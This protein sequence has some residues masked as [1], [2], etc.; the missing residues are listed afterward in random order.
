M[1]AS[2]GVVPHAERHELLLAGGADQL[3]QIGAGRP[4]RVDGDGQGGRPVALDGVGRRDQLGRRL[5]DPRHLLRLPD[6]AAA[7]ALVVP[8]A[9]GLD[10]EGGGHGV[11]E[12]G[13]GVAGHRA[14]LAGVALDGPGGL[15]RVH[16]PGITGLG[17][18]GH[19]GRRGGELDAVGQLGATWDGGVT[20]RRTGACAATGSVGGGPSGA[21]AARRFG[22][23]QGHR[24][25]GHPPAAVQP[26]NR[27]RLR[28]ADDVGR[29]GV[30]RPGSASPVVCRVIRHRWFTFRRQSTADVAGSSVPRQPQIT[31]SP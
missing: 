27:R 17:V 1:A 13:D 19:D 30:P 8:H 5:P 29:S 3:Q 22:D 18:L 25:G 6:Q 23:A 2:R 4:G 15:D 24:G 21:V 16:P 7:D 26:M 10:V 11:H 31:R 12:Q 9:V 20:C 14:D 28:R